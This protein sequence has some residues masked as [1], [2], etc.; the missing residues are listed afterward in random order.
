[1][2][3]LCIWGARWSWGT[4]ATSTLFLALLCCRRISLDQSVCVMG[5]PSC[6]TKNLILSRIWDSGV[7]PI[8]APTYRMTTEVLEERKVEELQASGLGDFH[9]EGELGQILE[10]STFRVEGIPQ[11]GKGGALR[12]LGP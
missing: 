10:G 9:R 8:P 6:I 5:I 7:S 3:G 4:P 1:M 11:T 2:M 12:L